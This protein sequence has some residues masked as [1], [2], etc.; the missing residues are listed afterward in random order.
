M[1]KVLLVALVLVLLGVLLVWSSFKARKRRGLGPGETVALDD[2]QLFSER[3]RLVG[4]PD[5]IVRQGE[6]YIPEEWKLS[7]KR[8]KTQ[9]RYKNRHRVRQPA[10]RGSSWRDFTP[11]LRHLDR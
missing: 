10:C 3:L 5:R 1:E 7:A 6:H 8:G 2:V 4:R 11:S 9:Q